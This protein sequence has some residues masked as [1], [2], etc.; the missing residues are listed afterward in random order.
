MQPE[1][2]MMDQFFLDMVAPAMGLDSLTT[3][4]PISVQVKIQRGHGKRS[5]SVLLGGLYIC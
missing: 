4:H 5:G 1:W 3:S 2:R